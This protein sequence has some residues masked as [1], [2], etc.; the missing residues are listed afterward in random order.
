[1]LAPNNLARAC[2]ENGQGERE[3]GLEIFVLQSTTPLASFEVVPGILG[4]LP[5]TRNSGATTPFLRN[6]LQS[7]CPGTEGLWSPISRLALSV[8]WRRSSLSAN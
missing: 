4:G 1:M 5:G 3:L 2:L 6:G 8:T 7:P